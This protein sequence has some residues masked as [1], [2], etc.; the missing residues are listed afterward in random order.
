MGILFKRLL[1]EKGLFLGMIYA[2]VA[3]NIAGNSEE[4]FN[5]VRKLG[6]GQEIEFVRGVYMDVSEAKRLGELTKGLRL[7]IH[8]P[9]YI[10]LSSKEKL[11]IKQS[12]QRILK[13]CEVGHYLGAQNIVF[14]AGYYQGRDKKE[15]Y[16]IIK[17]EVKEMMKVIKEKKWKV[18]LCPETT[19]KGTQFGDLDELLSLMKETG[20]S[21]CVDFAHLKAR[22]NGKIDFG[23]VLDKIKKNVHG[24]IH[25]HYSG[26]DYGLKGEKKHLLTD[27]KEFEVIAKE[28]IKRKM[29]FFIVN[30]SPD[31]LGDCLKMKK[32]LQHL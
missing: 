30:E 29:D 6:I 27:M 32:V 22:Y 18:K 3:G 1:N 17:E 28:I 9:Y 15:I 10:N 21:I 24:E 19:G 11:K 20:C 31:P 25:A 14:H 2:G 23:K 26:I 7:S 16:N 8:A 4:S 5:E 13:C 12:K